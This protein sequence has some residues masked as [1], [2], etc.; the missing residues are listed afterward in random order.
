MKAEYHFI[1]KWLN[2]GAKREEII[3]K[4]Q[5]MGQKHLGLSAE[6]IEVISDMDNYFKYD[7]LLSG[8]KC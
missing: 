1:Q 8:L 6:I 7:G 5:I 3:K 4:G 2:N